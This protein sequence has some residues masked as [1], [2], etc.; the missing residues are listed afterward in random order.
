MVNKDV[1]ALTVN[2]FLQKEEKEYITSNSYNFFQNYTLEKN[3]FVNC[4]A[5]NEFL[6]KFDRE[7][8]ERELILDRICTKNLWTI[9]KEGPVSLIQAGFGETDIGYII[10]KEPHG[11]IK[12]FKD[13]ELT[14]ETLP[15]NKENL[16]FFID[17]LKH[18]EP[19][20]A[21]TM[22]LV[23]QTTLAEMLSNK[24]FQLG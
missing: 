9:N 24:L 4:F 18:T 14:P 10:T 5:N 13:I 3:P 16:N 8:E 7:F 15:F 2:Y 22:I 12:S 19:Q 11:S 17:R 21:E 1:K 6:F 20:N 23:V